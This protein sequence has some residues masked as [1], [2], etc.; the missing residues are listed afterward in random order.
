MSAVLRSEIKVV[1]SRERTARALPC[2][3]CPADALTVS[4]S[5]L[6]TVKAAHARG[7]H[8]AAITMQHLLEWALPHLDIHTIKD[9]N[10]MT[11]EI[12]ENLIKA[13]G[14]NKLTE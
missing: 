10:R 4:R 2:A 14:E 8:P 3:F 11:G 6:V 1:K 12:L 9:I 13:A 5:G 7:V